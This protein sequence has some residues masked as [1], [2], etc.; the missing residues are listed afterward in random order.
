LAGIHFVCFQNENKLEL[1]KWNSLDHR[2]ISN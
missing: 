2:I 1:D